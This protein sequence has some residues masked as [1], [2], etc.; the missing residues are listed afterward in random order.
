MINNLYIN[1]ALSIK[2][3]ELKNDSIT[4]SI[5]AATS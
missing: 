3:L 5:Q 1:A 4:I 2:N